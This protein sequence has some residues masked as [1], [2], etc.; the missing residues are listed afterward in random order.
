MKAFPSNCQLMVLQEQLLVGG[1]LNA[2][3]K[4]SHRLPSSDDAYESFEPAT[5]MLAPT[6]P[7][8]PDSPPRGGKPKI[9][10]SSPAAPSL[11]IDSESSQ[12]SPKQPELL[13]VPSK[14]SLT[15]DSELSPSTPKQPVAPLSSPLAIGSQSSQSTPKQPVVPVVPPKDDQS[16]LLAS[17]RRSLQRSEQELCAQ[18]SQTPTSSLN[19]ARRA[20]LAAAKRTQKCILCLAEEALGF[21]SFSCWRIVC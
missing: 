1:D 6:P 18:L 8:T 14:S 21:E 15:L 17:L 4:A 19:D 13:E 11:T 9:P 3:Q 2:F 5:P 12:P 10:L 16:L 20:F 7:T